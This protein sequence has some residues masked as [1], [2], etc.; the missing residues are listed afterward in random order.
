MGPYDC[1]LSGRQGT[2]IQSD[3]KSPVL[4][5]FKKSSVV[6]K[7]PYGTDR[8]ARTPLKL[9]QRKIYGTADPEAEAE[10]IRPDNFSAHDENIQKKPAPLKRR[11]DKT[12]FRN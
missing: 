12:D 6:N 4:H 7:R 10:D 2:G 5:I 3:R 11:P 1:G 8:A 9:G